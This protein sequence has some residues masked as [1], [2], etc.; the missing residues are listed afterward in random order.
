VAMGSNLLYP[1]VGITGEAAH[2]LHIQTQWLNV[3]GFLIRAAV[4]FAFWILLTLL[5]ARWSRQ[6]DESRDPA[7]SV[8]LQRISA[9][10]LIIY[11]MTMSFAAIDWVMSR[12]L[13]WFSTIIGFLMVG[14]QGVTAMAFLIIILA[15]L[16][17][18]E[19]FHGRLTRGHFHDLGNLLLTLV[20]LWSYMSFAQFLIIWSGNL[21][22]FIPWYVNRRGGLWGWVA[23]A[24]VLFH[25]FVPF[26]ILLSRW[27][28]R[29]IRV[30]G[31]VAA[32]VL[33]MRVVDMCWVVLPTGAPHTQHQMEQPQPPRAAMVQVATAGPVATVREGVA[34]GAAPV[35]APRHD[36]R[37]GDWT[38]YIEPIAVLAALAGVGGVW[39]SAYLLLLP[40]RPMLARRDPLDEPSHLEV[41]HG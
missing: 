27:S 33:V 37:R 36:E 40:R 1:W 26:F 29:R 32:L 23:V 10:G 4:Y 34:L 31:T 24:L 5:L 6:R 21:N 17:R 11:F 16:V 30:I 15:V 35:P 22:E 8:R 28:K 2:A 9:A 19:P 12:E 13:E 3:P 14:G 25:F 20:I 18:Y 39:L 7:W 38:D 41:N